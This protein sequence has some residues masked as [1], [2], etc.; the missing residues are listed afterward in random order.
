MPSINR[1]S[2]SHQWETRKSSGAIA[3]TAATT[4]QKAMPATMTPEAFSGCFL[5]I[6]LGICRV[7]ETL[8]GPLPAG[9]REGPLLMGSPRPG[10][11][12][13]DIPLLD[14]QQPSPSI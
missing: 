10:G 2:A 1:L 14:S 8:G 11:R 12:G 5:T 6:D 9:L 3:L 7:A 4:K 13:S